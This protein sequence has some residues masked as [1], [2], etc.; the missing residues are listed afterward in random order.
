[1]VA[2]YLVL[3]VALQF[4]EDVKSSAENS[5]TNAEGKAKRKLRKMSIL[6]KQMCVF[7]ELHMFPFF[8]LSKNTWEQM[9]S[10]NYNKWKTE[11]RGEIWKWSNPIYSSFVA[12]LKEVMSTWDKSMDDQL[13]IE[14]W[15]FP[16]IL[17]SDRD[18]LIPASSTWLHVNLG[19]MHVIHQHFRGSLSQKSSER[20]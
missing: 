5:R 4:A 8:W 10:K 14:L 19:V 15:D 17:T 2:F 6:C 11:T 13:C 3:L 7:K 9:R 16:I 1:M 20:S 12:V 18:P